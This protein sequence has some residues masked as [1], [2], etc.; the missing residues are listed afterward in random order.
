MTKSKDILMLDAG[1]AFGLQ[2]RDNPFFLEHFKMIDQYQLADENLDSYKCLV[3]SMFVDQEFLVVQKEKIRRFLDNKN[4]IIFSGHLFRNWLPGTSHFVPRTIHSHLDYVVS[5]AKPHPIFEGVDSDAMTYNKGVAGF[6]ARGHHP[7]PEGAEV[8]L[9]LPENEPVTYID[10]N[11]TNGIILVH[12]GNDLFGYMDNEKSTDRISSQLLQWI[13]EE[14]QQ[15]QK[16]C[17]S[18]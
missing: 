10:R 6:F 9:T 16:G 2:R 3:I 15:L 11:S 5:I 14:Y 8:L 12:A 18:L 13:H 4:I 17:S 1:N 7:I